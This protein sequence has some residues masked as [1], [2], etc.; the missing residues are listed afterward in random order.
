VKFVA[1]LLGI[2]QGYER[3][4]V[5]VCDRFLRDAQSNADL[6][7]SISD[8]NQRGLRQFGGDDSIQRELWTRF[9]WRLTNTTTRGLLLQ[10]RYRARATVEQPLRLAFHE[11]AGVAPALQPW[12][13]ISIPAPGGSASPN[14]TYSPAPQAQICDERVG[15]R[16]ACQCESSML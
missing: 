2:A 7:K 4:R 3:A 16:S 15:L 13:Q 8:D 1:D 12:F 9:V 14:T 6:A 5:A 10:A 11:M